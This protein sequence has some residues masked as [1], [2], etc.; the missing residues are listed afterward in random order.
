MIIFQ[1][2]MHAWLSML[3][4]LC[5]HICICGIRR[6]KTWTLFDQDWWTWQEHQLYEVGSLNNI[7]TSI[8][9]SKKYWCI[10]IMRILK[11]SISCAGLLFLIFLNLIQGMWESYQLPVSWFSLG[12]PAFR[13]PLSHN[14][15]VMTKQQYG[16]RKWWY[17]K[18]KIS[19]WLKKKIVRCFQ[20]AE[21]RG[22]TS[23]HQGL[24]QEA[25]ALPAETHPLS[26]GRAQQHPGDNIRS[27]TIQLPGNISIRRVFAH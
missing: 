1:A 25:G 22:R 24:D 11:V 16:R 2:Y 13:L 3:M 8:E 14:W 15:L 9:T 7:V 18:F 20:G 19:F 12:T 21:D 23:G 10:C 26:G 4:S 27:R 17:T 5:T 6:V